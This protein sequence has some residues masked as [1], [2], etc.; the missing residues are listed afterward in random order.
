MIRCTPLCPDG[1]ASPQAGPPC[2]LDSLLAE[3]CAPVLLGCKP[4]NLVSVC[5]R[6]VPALP[7]LL[8]GCRRW[9]EPRGVRLR[10]LCTCRERWLLLVYRPAMLARALRRPGA[11]DLLRRAGCP[12]GGVEPRL[13]WLAGRLAGGGAFPHVI[14]LFLGYPAGDV[15]GF[16]RSGGRDC[17]LCGYWKVYTDVDRARRRFTLYDDCRARLCGALA[18]GDTLRCRLAG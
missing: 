3:H 18:G 5:R 2:A 6:R 9:L 15:I 13:D 1:A 4:A 17:R 11:A 12:E 14:G 10:L 8:A 16:C 7:G